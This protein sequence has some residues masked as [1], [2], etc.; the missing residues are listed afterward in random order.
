M[1]F[2]VLTAGRAIVEWYDAPAGAKLARSARAEPI[3]VASGQ[4]VFTAARAGKLKLKLT[5][6]GKHLLKHGKRVRVTA[7][8]VFIAA[9]NAAVRATTSFTLRP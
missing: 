6:A 9:G 5:A 8:G 1:P 4:V 2:R 3:L 7:K